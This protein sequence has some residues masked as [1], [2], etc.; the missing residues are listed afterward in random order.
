MG[1]TLLHYHAAH[2]PYSFT[3]ASS[4]LDRSR[5][6]TEADT[7]L[8]KCYML[9]HLKLWFIR[10]YLRSVYE[11]HLEFVKQRE[12]AT[13]ER[14]RARKRR[15]DASEDRRAAEQEREVAKQRRLQDGVAQEGVAQESQV[16]DEEAQ[17]QL[18]EAGLQREEAFLQESEQGYQRTVFSSR[19]EEISRQCEGQSRQREYASREREKDSRVR[20]RKSRE[21]EEAV[22]QGQQDGSQQEPAR[23]QREDAQ[24]QYNED[25]QVLEEAVLQHRRRCHRIPV[26]A[27]FDIRLLSPR[28]K[29]FVDFIRYQ[30]VAWIHTLA[31]LTLIAGLALLGATLIKIGL[32]I[33][34]AFI[35]VI[36]CGGPVLGV[37]PPTFLHFIRVP[38]EYY[39]MG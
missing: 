16:Q 3:A 7:E 36:T 6:R 2:Q 23:V 38:E 19:N 20:E 24:K 35:V 1:S 26:L 15:E 21:R 10:F 22:S 12:Q 9:D 14:F 34:G 28:H 25:R 5:E 29:S 4:G 32:V 8:A 30:K 31:F 17:I 18:N 33:E 27:S 39:R 13:R 11:K 37:G